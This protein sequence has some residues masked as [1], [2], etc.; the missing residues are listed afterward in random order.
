MVRTLGGTLLIHR[1]WLLIDAIETSTMRKKW[2]SKEE[3]YFG[4]GVF[5][6][7]NEENIG[8][9]WRTAYIYGASFIFI[10]D[11][12]YK[13]NTSDVLKVWSKIPLLQF[14]SIDAFIQTV[15]YSC[16]II[17]IEIDKEATPIKEFAH[18][19]RAIYLLLYYRGLCR[20][21]H[22]IKSFTNAFCGAIG[23]VYHG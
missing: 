19:E 13:K 14:E 21:L 18:P 23:Q 4:I 10:I 3:R 15:P 22:R 11:A 7:K 9:L 17:G 2:D 20:V 1:W 5:R 8:S 16:K 12:K 6:P